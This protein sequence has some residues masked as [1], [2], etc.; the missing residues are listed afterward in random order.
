MTIIHKSKLSRFF[1]WATISFLIGSLAFTLLAC[2]NTTFISVTPE[3]AKE[4]AASK[5]VVYLD[6]RTVLE[7]TDGHIDGAVNLDY[8]HNNFENSLA[9]LDKSMVYI[10]YCQ[11]G[12]RSKNT[13]KIMWEMQFKEAYDIKGGITAWQNAGYPVI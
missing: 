4:I 5:A 1:L 2:V 9:S 8:N 10:V 6:V 3:K 11:A 7:Y 12:V 13:L